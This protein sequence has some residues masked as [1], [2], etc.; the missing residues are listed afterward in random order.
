MNLNSSKNK[1]FHFIQIYRETASY[2]KYISTENNNL[3]ITL[4]GSSFAILFTGA[5]LRFLIPAFVL[6]AGGQESLVSYIFLSLLLELLSVVCYII[7][8]YSISHR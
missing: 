3:F 8:L 1:P 2:L 6:S 7:K 5:I 4:V